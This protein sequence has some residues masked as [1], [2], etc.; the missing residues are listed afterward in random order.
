MVR[1][2]LTDGHEMV[3]PDDLSEGP[4]VPEKAPSSRGA[5]PTPPRRCRSS[6]DHRVDYLYLA[7]P[8]GAH[9]MFERDYVIFCPHRI[10]GEFEIIGDRCRNVVRI[11]VSLLMQGRAMLICG[12]GL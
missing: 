2:L 9:E 10:Y 5:S 4:L 7:G 11:C 3:V 8:E 1:S 6:L 12:D